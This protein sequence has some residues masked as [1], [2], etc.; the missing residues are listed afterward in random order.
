MTIRDRPQFSG[1]VQR[2]I[3]EAVT[4]DDITRQW[5]GVS[6]SDG[7]SETDTVWSNFSGDTHLL[8]HL[9]IA[10]ASTDPLD[11]VTIEL[12][13]DDGGGAPF[14]WR[15]FSHGDRFPLSFDPP[16]P[17]GD[18]DSLIITVKNNSGSNKLVEYSAIIRTN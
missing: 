14:P 10:E 17:I 2:P 7:E 15:I 3:D 11:G 8:D 1:A 13:I 4:R 5:D 18:G 6:V 12:H 16:M 9:F